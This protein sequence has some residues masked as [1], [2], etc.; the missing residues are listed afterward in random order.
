[1]TKHHGLGGLN[2]GNGF[3]LNSG[4]KKSGITVLTGL[5]PSE[6]TLGLHMLYLPVSF[7]LCVSVSQPLL[8]RTLT[9]LVRVSPSLT[10]TN[11][12]RRCPQTQVCSELLW[13]RTLL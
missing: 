3:S 11:S 13:I 9:S 10:L 4:D 6:A 12:L 2:C 1:M 5:A 8:I 7:P